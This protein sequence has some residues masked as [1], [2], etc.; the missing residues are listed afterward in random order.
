MIDYMLPRIGGERLAGY[1]QTVWRPMMPNYADR[2]QMGVETLCAAKMRYE[3][4][5]AET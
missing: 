3:A 5:T 4:L 1:M 2:Q